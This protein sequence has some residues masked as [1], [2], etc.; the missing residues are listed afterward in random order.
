MQGKPVFR[1]EFAGHRSV[2]HIAVDGCNRRL[3]CGVHHMSVVRERGSGALRES[4]AATVGGR[5]ADT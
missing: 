1:K 2:I 4:P 5:G 3:F